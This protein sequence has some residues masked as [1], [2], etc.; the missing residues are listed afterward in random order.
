[1]FT[2]K[3][4]SA[5]IHLAESKTFA[6]AADKLHVTQPALSTSIKK[7]EEQLGGQ[8]FSR[9]TR[10][11]ALTQE[12]RTFLPQAK[13]LMM[14]WSN[15]F[16]DIQRLFSIQQGSL[17]VAAMPSFAEGRLP[18]FIAKFHS[19]YPNIKIRVLDVV[20]EE[21]IQNVQSGAAE[22]G[23]TFKPEHLEG[24]EFTKLFDDRFIVVVHKSHP[25]S[26]LQSVSW[27]DAFDNDFVAMNRNSSVRN[28][29]ETRAGEFDKP[30]R[31][32]AEANQLGT[33]GQLVSTGVG[34]SIVPE[35]CR[36]QMLSKHLICIPLQTDK[37]TKPVGMLRNKREP[38]SAA[39]KGLWN[40]VVEN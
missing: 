1:M 34:I 24:L 39:A 6:E 20:M 31:L 33:V 37:L 17:T 22:I 26:K 3:T 8:L 9:T 21:V 15:S 30:L 2:I 13:R 38:L 18:T 16:A 28:W 7:L 29:I 32:V 36:Q 5:F 40:S 12:G 11:V 25:Y 19:L 4:V 35:L 10:N 14:D 23:F 27:E